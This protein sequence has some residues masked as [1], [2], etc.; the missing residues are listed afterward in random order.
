M[1]ICLTYLNVKNIYF[2]F[3]S[4]HLASNSE[5][6]LAASNFVILYLSP[7]EFFHSLKPLRPSIKL[8]SDL[9]IQAITKYCNSSP[10]TRLI[11]FLSIF[12]LPIQAGMICL[13]F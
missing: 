3:S 5:F 6:S 1:F 7:Y 12:K 10:T 8:F 2:Y 4:I 13:L 11:I 9:K